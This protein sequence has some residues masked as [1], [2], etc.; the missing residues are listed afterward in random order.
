MW[1]FLLIC[2][3]QRVKKI[4]LLIFSQ[5][6]FQTL[7]SVHLLRGQL[8]PPYSFWDWMGKTQGFNA[9]S[10]YLLGEKT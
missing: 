10:D 6:C 5:S 1:I 9:F 7:I 4:N 2:V 3:A 8:L